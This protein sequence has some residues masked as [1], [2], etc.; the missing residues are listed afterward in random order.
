MSITEK[1]TNTYQK[2]K[3]GIAIAGVVLALGGAYYQG[4]HDKNVEINQR[5]QD[6]DMQ[7]HIYMGRVP[8]DPQKDKGIWQLEENIGTIVRLMKENKKEE[9]ETQWNNYLEE[10]RKFNYT[11]QHY[12]T[13]F[14]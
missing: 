1:L 9:R 3:K 4:R 5:L 2:C 13:N 12:H 11:G 8:D 7:I 10:M 6:L 14:N